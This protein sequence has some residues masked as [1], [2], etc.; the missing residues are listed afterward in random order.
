MEGV[1][2]YKKPSGM[3]S[4]A[5]HQATLSLSEEGQNHVRSLGSFRYL[6]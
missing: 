2:T 6:T 3:R 5:D 4:G 1:D